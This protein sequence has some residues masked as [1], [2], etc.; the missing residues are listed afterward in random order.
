MFLIG[1]DLPLWA[2]LLCVAAA[3]LYWLGTNTYGTFRSLG[4]PY[5]TASIPFLGN[6]IS[7]LS[8]PIPDEDLNMVKKFP[9]KV[10]GKFLGK[11]PVLCIAD[12]LVNKEVTIKQWTKFRNHS[13]LLDGE[14]N[15]HT[16][17]V[18]ALEDD[19]WKHVRS[20]LSPALSSGKLKQMLPV[21]KIC[22]D[23]LNAH[24]R[25]T[26]SASV[27]IKEYTG[28][29]T[30]N[31]IAS[32]AF[33]M[34][35]DTHTTTEHPFVEHA[36]RIMGIKR[37]TT[38]MAKL[39]GLIM[40]ISLFVLPKFLRIFLST[41]CG[42]SFADPESVAYF[43]KAI[44]QYT[45]GYEPNEKQQNFLSICYP[46]VVDLDKIEKTE[47]RNSHGFSWTTA[48][49]TRKD[50]IAN[51]VIFLGAGYETTATALQFSLY[52]MALHP[53][54][55]DKLYSEVKD[56]EEDF[57]YECLQNLEYLDWTIKESLRFFPPV[58]RL[59]R[60]TVEDATI[61]D[62]TIPKG[63]MISCLV[64]PM[65]HDPEYWPNP[66]TFDPVRFSPEQRTEI[67]QSAFLPFGAGSRNCLA[68]R[69]A[70]LELKVSLVKLVKEFRFEK[71]SKTPGLNS[72]FKKGLS[73]LD[74]AEPIEISAV[75]R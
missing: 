57:S 18:G 69:L 36:R 74:M 31:V 12:P 45:Q 48:G 11:K 75:P 41:H 71:T 19:H 50:F 51:A 26:E 68:S 52:A 29:Y 37:A 43:T 55:Q 65:H 6:L 64:Y 17:H 1:V 60:A 47:I 20:T 70:L 4:I 39:R 9:G 5:E 34:D 42:L 67:Q 23:K 8:K 15:I 46:K 59:D 16:R 44:D 14:D 35:I 3:L 53:H 24:L 38:L 62:F 66:E 56:V 25:R 72:G 54:I 2:A 32:T 61:N 27:K 63:M 7:S 28:A 40:M 58:L 30:M 10:F 13:G 22:A 49:L 21:I 33:G 73:F